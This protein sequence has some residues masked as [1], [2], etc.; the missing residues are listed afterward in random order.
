MPNSII[1]ARADTVSKE[2]NTFTEASIADL[3]ILKPSVFESLAFVGISTT[4]PTLPLLIKSIILGFSS[5]AFLT[6]IAL[7][8]LSLRYWAVFSV[9]AKLYP[10]FQ[11]F[12]FYTDV[13]NINI[14]IRNA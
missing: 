3:L 5:L 7:I 2:V 4:N 8:P 6:V 11:A 10:C 14:L 13:I 9:A 1:S 12:I